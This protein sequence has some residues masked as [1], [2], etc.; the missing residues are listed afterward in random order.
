MVAV[1]LGSEIVVNAI[2]S[3]NQYR[4]LISKLASGG[5]VIGWQDDSGLGSP[6]DQSDDVRFARFDAFGNRLNAG[7]DTQ[8]NT[9]HASAQFEGAVA[10]F[11]DGKFVLAWTDASE[12]GLD[13]DN[14]A[15]RMQIFNANGTK[16]GSEILVNATYT[17]SQDQPSITV[18]TGGNIV[19][20]W[21][22]EDI[23]DSSH[24]NVIRRVFNASG[25]PLTGEQFVNTQTVGDQERS[26]VH[27]LSS[28]GF[29]VVWEDRENSVATGFQL[30]TYIRFYSAG[31]AAASAPI[32]LNN[33]TARDPQQTGFAEL[34][35]GNIVVTWTEADPL[36]PGDA[37]GHSIKA[38][39]Y[40]PATLTF[41]GLINVNT[42]TSFDQTDAQVAALDNGQF[43]VVWYDLNTAGSDTSFGSVKLQ[44]FNASGGKVGTEI[45]VNDQTLFEQANPVVTVLDDFRFVVAWEDRSQIAG[46]TDGYSIHSRIFD[47]RIAGINVTGDTNS[48]D[49][50]GSNFGDTINGLGGAD[51]LFGGG[52]ID[53]LFGGAG[54]DT[55]DGGS[56][57]DQ[58]NGGDGDDIY[59]VD[60]TLD[61]I[62][63][64]PGAL[65]GNDFIFSTANYT[66]AANCERLYLSG[67]A[68]L[69]ATGRA[70]QNDSLFGNSGANILNG[71]AGIDQMSGLAGND[72][73]AVDNALDAVFEGAG[74]GTDRVY[75]SVSYTLA[76][77][78]QIETLSTSNNA[79]TGAINL[80]GNNL[81]NA[82]IGN[83]GANVLNGGGAADLMSGMGGNDS[84]AVD[85]VL[86]TVIETVGGGSDRVYA[87]VSYT[88][89]AGQEIETLSTY[90][91]A[92]NVA[93]NLTGNAFSNALI[94]NAGANVLN[95]AGG[96]DNMTGLGGNDS[97]S[98]D[99]ALDNVIEAVGGGA[100]RIYASVSYTLDAGQEVEILSTSNN[101]GVTAIN[102]TGNEF[103]NT[104]IGNA[105]ANLLLGGTGND[106][107]TGLG[108][109][110]I[111]V[112]NTALNS[113]TNHDTIT[114]F[115][116]PDDTIR[117]ENAV[118]ALLTVTGTLASA[119][120]KDITVD[121]QD[122]N[123]VIIYNRTTGNLFY[124]SNALAAG[125]QTWF[126]DVTNGTVLTFA[127][128]VV[129]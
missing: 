99:N 87:S 38:R 62:I 106:T 14:R 48:N 31:G 44:V 58:M 117:L 53:F 112:F 61:V 105:G 91:N 90:N 45:R 18:L 121:V 81:V 30:E 22:S 49:Y 95:G 35:N 27:A 50:V 63:E 118:F 56:S 70:D 101:A 37:S 115:S 109:A 68:N 113:L 124:D 77:G 107:L 20:T 9:T 66:M 85:N 126:A 128:F 6:A 92:S 78:Q 26:T 79:G 52:G 96:A 98:V 89:G 21:T 17:L 88:L 111:F 83:A 1:A 19:V 47:A 102:L 86:D 34:S 103:N 129:V 116:V 80:T 114:D 67:S 33:S 3:G 72:S 2:H 15:V 29:A 46:D 36:S 120:F 24:T 10:A 54:G 110:D 28:G 32:V 84:Y 69:N 64:A 74:G 55:L 16:S 65:G 108:G 11:D 12:S 59:Y 60:S 94:G 93:I 5:F 122:A 123:D 25:S 23:N 104:L 51:K 8:A 71:L 39:I 100:D 42:T 57:S 41:S 43:V 119:W 40:N 7:V 73:Y 125:G 82:L 127:D 4:P 75:A 97:Y 76:A 13:T